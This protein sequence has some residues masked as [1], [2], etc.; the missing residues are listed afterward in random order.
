MT[1]FQELENAGLRPTFSRMSIL[2]LFSEE[3]VAHLSAEDVHQRLQT[4]GFR[5]G[6]ATV[7]RV[8]T[9]FEHAGLLSRHKWEDGRAVYELTS[10]DH[11]DHMICTECKK[12]IEFND[13]TI[14]ERKRK[15]VE[16]AGYVLHDH[17][18]YLYV[19]CTDENCPGK[20]SKS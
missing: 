4:N 11:H 12:L 7:Y 6:L 9:Q 1:K 18:L 15:I 2:N 10:E 5:I 13:P 16:E 8:L 17:L 14:E 3:G 19:S 20:T